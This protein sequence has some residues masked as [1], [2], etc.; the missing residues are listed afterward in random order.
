MNFLNICENGMCQYH[1]PV[2]ESL[3][4]ISQN[5]LGYYENG[6]RAPGIATIKLLCEGLGCTASELMGF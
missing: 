6:E 5:V 1:K 3:D 2:P 4:D